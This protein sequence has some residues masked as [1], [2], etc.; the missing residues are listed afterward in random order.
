VVIIEPNMGALLH[1]LAHLRPDDRREVFGLR[2]T[3]DE[4]LVAQEVID[5]GPPSW[6]VCARDGEPVY[7]VGLIASRPGVWACWGFGTDRWPEVA[8]TV[9]RLL[10]K[11]VIPGM[12]ASGAHR[13]EAVSII[14]KAAAHRWLKHIGANDEAT[15]LGYGRNGETYKM[16]AWRV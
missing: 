15:L 6:V 10:R 7:A 12:I 16:F 3:D 11:I 2:W 14:D 9:T 8:I 13:V 1:I 4:E 5:T